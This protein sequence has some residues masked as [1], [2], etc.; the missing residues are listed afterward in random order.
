MEP[1]DFFSNPRSAFSVCALV[2]FIT[3]LTT[4]PAIAEALNDAGHPTPTGGRWR[5]SNVGTTITRYRPKREAT[6]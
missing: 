3:A 2:V 1:N 5:T 4:V 6:P